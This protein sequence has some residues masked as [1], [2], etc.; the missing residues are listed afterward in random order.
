MLQA[1]GKAPRVENGAHLAGGIDHAVA[2]GERASST[3]LVIESFEDAVAIGIHGLRRQAQLVEMLCTLWQLAIIRA[4]W[5]SRSD[6]ESK[7]ESVLLRLEGLQRVAG[8]LRADICWPAKTW[9]IAV[10]ISSSPAPWSCAGGAGP[11]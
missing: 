6:S 5:I 10:T 3:S 4:I 2:D 7:G 8:D 11:A 9:R 1:A